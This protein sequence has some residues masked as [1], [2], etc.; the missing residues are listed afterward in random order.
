MRVKI[1]VVLCGT[2]ADDNQRDNY[3]S[4]REKNE[5]FLWGINGKLPVVR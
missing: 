3:R 4:V 1:S 2:P 5:F